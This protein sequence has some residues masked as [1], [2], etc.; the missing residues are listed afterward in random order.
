[1]RTPFH[2][3]LEPRFVAP[4]EH[5]LRDE[6]LAAVNRDL[7]AT[8]PDQPPL[9]LVACP[10]EPEDEEPE[11]VHVA[12]ADG[13]THGNF[14]QPASSAADA[15]HIVAE[16]AQETVMECLW[17]AWPVCAL[18]GLGTH[19]TLDAGR[20]SWWCGGTDG[21]DG[22][23]HLHAAVGETDRVRP[24]RRPNREPRADGTAHGRR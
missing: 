7:A 17:L 13:S 3:P 22:P 14:L 16:A 2:H 10:G 4:G 11:R 21:P 6:A 20:S 15:L 18:H 8:L 5:P 19:L 12:L 24:P 1:M 9:C 23:G